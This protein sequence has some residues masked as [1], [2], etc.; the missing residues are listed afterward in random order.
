[1][2]SE[3]TQTDFCTQADFK[4]WYIGTKLKILV[5]L[6]IGLARVGPI[7]DTRRRQL[8]RNILKVQILNSYLVQI[9]VPNSKQLK[10]WK[11]LIQSTSNVVFT[12]LTSQVDHSAKRISIH[13]NSNFL[14]CK[15][16]IADKLQL[17]I[18]SGCKKLVPCGR[19]RGAQRFTNYH[20]QPRA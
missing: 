13:G 5:Q 18:F 20:M 9:L 7:T 19:R 6:E 8:I 17:Y 1:M 16:F 4:F 10:Q 11:T 3:S 14:S 15:R 12:N 2:Q